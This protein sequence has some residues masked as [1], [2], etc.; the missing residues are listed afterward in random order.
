MERKKNDK[1]LADFWGLMDEVT[2]KVVEKN[3]QEFT[4]SKTAE[5]SS[6]EVKG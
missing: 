2:V 3:T 5:S 6:T 4:K 1:V